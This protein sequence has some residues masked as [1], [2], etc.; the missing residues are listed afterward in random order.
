MSDVC[1]ICGKKI[2]GMKDASVDHIVPLSRGGRDAP[3]NMQIAHK[4]CNVRKGD[5]I[6]GESAEE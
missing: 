6:Y 2:E 3:D 5:K 1:G 4:E